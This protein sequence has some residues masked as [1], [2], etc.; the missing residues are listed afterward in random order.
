MAAMA[1][2]VYPLSV[3]NATRQ[4]TTAI[5]E[6]ITEIY[7]SQNII[8]Q[9]R[10][11]LL[12]MLD[13]IK[14]SNAAPAISAGRDYFS[15]ALKKLF[16]REIPVNPSGTLSRIKEEIQIASG[17]TPIPVCF[18]QTKTPAEYKGRE[19]AP[20][21]SQMNQ[22][23][24]QFIKY[25]FF[26]SGYKPSEIVP[27]VYDVLTFGSYID[28][29]KRKKLGNDKTLFV[30]EGEF[31][32]GGA[33]AD[34]RSVLLTRLG[35]GDALRSIIVGNLNAD[36]SLPVRLDI[37]GDGGDIINEL[38]DVNQHHINRGATNIDDGTIDYFEG[39]NNKNTWFN[40]KSDNFK[41]AKRFILCKVLGDAK[42]GLAAKLAIGDSRES[43]DLYI[44]NCLFTGDGVLKARCQELKVPVCVQEDYSGKE[45]ADLGKCCYYGPEL[46]PAAV[47]K[48]ELQAVLK[49]VIDSNR[50]VLDQ[51]ILLNNFLNDSTPNPFEY[52]RRRDIPGITIILGNRHYE[53]PAEQ[54]QSV[55]DFISIIITTIDIVI[56]FLNYI[57]KNEIEIPNI[58]DLYKYKANMVNDELRILKNTSLFPEI[59]YIGTQLV[60]DPIKDF[61]GSDIFGIIKSL[62]SIP[63]ERIPRRARGGGRDEVDSI[64]DTEFSYTYFDTISGI[65][66][67]LDV[68]A[69]ADT[70]HHIAPVNREDLVFDITYDFVNS[71]SSYFNYIGYSCLNVP[72]LTLLITGFLSGRFNMTLVD[73]RTLFFTLPLPAQLLADDARINAEAR[74]MIERQTLLIADLT[75]RGVDLDTAKKEMG[76]LIAPA[77]SSK[78]QTTRKNLVA[79]KAAGPKNITRSRSRNRL[80]LLEPYRLPVTRPSLFTQAPL[81]TRAAG[82]SRKNRKTR[83]HR[84]RG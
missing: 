56:Q 54:I 37:L 16:F 12:N 61:P 10:I 21:G 40:T 49:D 2:M 79:V 81:P 15:T 41:K 71:T 68:T 13:C 74:G 55:K 27:D 32:L 18:L 52:M 43:K 78:L 9:E 26:D 59:I 14:D 34:P 77:V 80:R 6:I 51:V 58:R 47:R 72:T 31:T 76:N 48:L 25:A 46:D 75:R 11:K 60:A 82:G 67:G 1:A 70:Y 35:F 69:L 62:R 20:P 38:R 28:P 83:K 65:I 63:F 19:L 39:N 22:N 53:I 36:G 66:S 33:A 4:R 17:I 24:L 23:K 3:A 42:L 30:S 8:K 50:K 73:F 45:Y 29:A 64:P 7:P 44:Q 84:R 57:R 5:D